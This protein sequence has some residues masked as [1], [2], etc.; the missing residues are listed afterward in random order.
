MHDVSKKSWRG[1]SKRD[2]AHPLYMRPGGRRQQPLLRKQYRPM[3]TAVL[4][5]GW[6]GLV[7]GTVRARSPRIMASGMMTVFPP[8]MMC[9]V[10][11]R[12]ALRLTLLPVSYNKTNAAFLS[13][14]VSYLEKLL[15]C[16]LYSPSL[17]ILPWVLF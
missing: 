8:S 13:V 16:I 15:S 5:P 11:T 7:D 2:C 10:P 14:N 4:L 1:K 12:V 3:K 6:L 17:S 9:C